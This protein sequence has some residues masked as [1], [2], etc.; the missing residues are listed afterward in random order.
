MFHLVKELPRSTRT[1][2]VYTWSLGLQRTCYISGCAS[3][4]PPTTNGAKYNRVWA[5]PSRDIIIII[6]I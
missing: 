6:I 3:L 1:G 2:P 5:W 4:A